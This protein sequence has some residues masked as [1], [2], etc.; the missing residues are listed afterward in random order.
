MINNKRVLA[1]V[2]ARGGSKGLPEKNIRPLLGKP[3]I[4]WTIAAG[5]AATSIDTLIVSTDDE[6]IAEI[7]KQAGARVPFARPAKLADDTASSIDVVLHAIDTLESMGE[8]YD[9]VILLEPTSPMRES[10]D[11]DEA[12]KKL[13]S[14]DAKSI[15]SVCHAESQHPAFMYRLTQDSLLNPFSGK[16][17]TNLRR[18]DI[19]PV[20]FLDGT[21]YASHI[22]VLRK[23]ESFYHDNT[24]AFEVPKYKSFEVDDIYDFITIEALMKYKEYKI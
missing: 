2:T 3:L 24:L 10:S 18:Q 22:E 9:I 11:I 21:L 5:K 15:V 17:P 8:Y 14:S 7:A 19:E 1:V 12:L 13:L 16:H 23:E 6:K 4:E 20:Y